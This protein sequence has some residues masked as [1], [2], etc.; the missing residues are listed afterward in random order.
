[1]TEAGGRFDRNERLFGKEG[2]AALRQASVAVVGVG[3]LGTHV[4]QQLSLLG[5]GALSLIDHEEL[6]TSNRNRYV[7][8]WHN[9]PVPDSPKVDL[10]ERL[11]RLVD[12]TISGR[13]V[14]MGFP[15]AP[16]LDAVRSADYVFACVDND[17]VRF[18][19]NETCLAYDRPLFDLASDVPEPGRYG[20]RVT[21]V[22]GDGGCLNCRG[23]LDPDEVRR[24]LSPLEALESEAAEYG[25][26][27][28]VL[29]TA[30][31]SVVSVN[32]VVASLG[33]T[34][35]MVAVTGMRP[36]NKHLEYRGHA[37]VVAKQRDTPSGECYYCDEIRGL[38]DVARIHR[39]FAL[40]PA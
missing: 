2:Q 35:F 31:P 40:R 8:A 27:R 30:G 15:S 26:D 9:D 29:G 11:V 28:Q 12:P 25:V 17:G 37:G 18:V 13:K 4:V 23:L 21:V 3:G 24:F 14:P 39:Y 7:G 6:A 32:G 22:W 34:E 16:A 36:P 33:V 38:G 5:V 20:G 10:A 19:L 1:M